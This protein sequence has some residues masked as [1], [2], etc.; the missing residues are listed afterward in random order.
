MPAPKIC[1]TKE[2]P[3]VDSGDSTAAATGSSLNNTLST[4][5]P[6][7]YYESSVAVSTATDVSFNLGSAVDVGAI[8]IDNINVSSND[9]EIYEKATSNPFTAGTL[10]AT[11]TPLQ[12]KK[13][14]RYKY[15]YERS[16][17]TTRQWYGIRIKANA[18]LTE[19][20]VARIGAVTFCSRANYIDL[21]GGYQYPMEY[22]VIKPMKE[23]KFS[24]GSVEPVS[25]GSRYVTL[26][27]PVVDFL[28]KSQQSNVLDIVQQE[29]S[30]LVFFENNSDL[31]NVYTCYVKSA[32]STKITYKLKE[33]LATSFELIEAI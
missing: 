3:T 29:V 11:V 9:I 14:G 24:G 15:I 28:K 33:V 26:Q 23:N 31:E 4:Q 25:L 6:L 1:L 5:R 12:D 22:T 19:G 17:T 13:T 2:T 21:V 32:K 8:F 30:T 27:L 16:A 20:T 7:R 18:T 10:L